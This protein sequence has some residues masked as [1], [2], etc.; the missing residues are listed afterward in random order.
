MEKLSYASRL[1]NKYC[2]KEHYGV[3]LDPVE[4]R[5]LIVW[6]DAMC[7]YMGGDDVRSAPDPKFQGSDW[8]ALPPR[9]ETAP[10]VKRPGPFNAF[11]DDEAYATPSA[12]AIY[13]NPADD[14][15]PTLKA[16]PRIDDKK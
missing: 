13:G 4:M 15:R 6:V 12:E 5:R 7:P 16:A 9:L 14:A 3:E 8:L 10:V 1:I 2:V 11:G